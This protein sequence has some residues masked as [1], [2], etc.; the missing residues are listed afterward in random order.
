MAGLPPSSLTLESR[1]FILRRLTKADASERLFSW[2][3]DDL[4]AEMLNTKRRQWSLAEQAAFF[5]G[6]PDKV[7]LAIVP[8]QQEYPIGF[9]SL[10]LQPRIG[11]FTI[12]HLI[13]D[14]AWRGK[15]LTAETSD[16]I[17][18]YL[19]NKLDYAKAKANVRPQNRPMLWL[20]LGG[21]NWRKEARLVGHLRDAETGERSDLLVLGMLAQ[22]WRAAREPR[23]AA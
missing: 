5:A 6:K 13:S 8:R 3:D 18:E 12:S 23:S 1:N 16:P 19:F 10:H 22:E 21:K 17:Y 15:D 7:L 20:M 9:Y 14:A 4:A 2:A 11:V